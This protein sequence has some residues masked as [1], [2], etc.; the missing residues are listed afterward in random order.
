M[1]L[2]FFSQFLREVGSTLRRLCS[3]SQLFS[4]RPRLPGSSSAGA[5]ALALKKLQERALHDKEASFSM[6]PLWALPIFCVNPSAEGACVHAA[7]FRSPFI[8]R[9]NERPAAHR[10]PPGAEP[11]RET[12]LSR[13]CMESTEA[14]W[15]R[16]RYGSASHIC[17][18]PS[19]ACRG[20]CTPGSPPAPLRLPGGGG[21]GGVPA[22]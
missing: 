20:C 6:D 11:G 10:R 16:A 4:L 7:C 18:H 19:I 12:Q 22:R 9:R 17:L 3:S 21:G 13:N 15:A 14:G 1:P 5:A 8:C 2:G